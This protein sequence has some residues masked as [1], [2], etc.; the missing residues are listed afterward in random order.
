M[1]AALERPTAAI[2]PDLDAIP[3]ELRPYKHFGVWRG[4]RRGDGF[5]KRPYTPVTGFAASSTKPL[6]WGTYEEACAAYRRGGWDGVGFFF[7]KGDAYADP[8]SVMDLDHVRDPETGQLDPWAEEVVRDA[9][10]NT[11]PSVSGT[12]VHIL[13]K[14]TLSGKGHNKELPGGGHLEIYD[15]AR[16]MTMTG[17]RVMGTPPRIESRQ[18]AIDYYYGLL[19]GGSWEDASAYVPPVGQPN[20]LTDEQVLEVAYRSAKGEKIHDLYAGSTAYHAGDDSGADL[21]LCNY[22]AFTCGNPEQVDRLFRASDLMRDKWDERRGAQTYGE[23]TLSKA[24]KDRTDYYSP[25]HTWPVLVAYTAPDAPAAGD[26]AELQEEILV[27]RAKV[28]QLEEV[29]AA[30]R[31]IIAT[32]RGENDE[33]RGVLRGI[34]DLHSLPDKDMRPNEKITTIE[35]LFLVY[36]RDSHQ[37]EGPPRFPLGRLIQRTGISRGTQGK[38]L[39]TVA[40]RAEM[41]FVKRTVTEM[42]DPVD[43]E[44]GEPLGGPQEPR[45]FVELELTRDVPLSMALA[46]AARS[47]PPN[48][49]THGGARPEHCP[50]HPDAKILT[51]RVCSTCERVLDSSGDTDTDPDFPMVQLA[52]SSPPAAH[53]GGGTLYGASPDIGAEILKVHDA[54]SGPSPQEL[55]AGWAE[56]YCQRHHRELSYPEMLAEACS[57][58][59]SATSPRNGH[60]P[61]AEATAWLFGG[62]S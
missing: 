24:F 48:R 47:T 16:F 19:G 27:L 12:G 23:L 40:A 45:K 33:F 20:G 13:V 34:H 7:H 61:P 29:N 26:C 4:E 43:P 5:T 55:L 37:A 32:L 15:R 31:E 41:P 54:P 6:T 14:G 3:T 44:T 52:P 22:L 28:A 46:I 51:R 58:C 49:A 9:D 8:F 10:S 59:T 42:V 21:A 53:V 30:Q 39:T 25:P 11:E 35:S 17:E 38:H 56:G 2:A 36:E 57:W 18:A 50:E 1:S 60:T 62:A